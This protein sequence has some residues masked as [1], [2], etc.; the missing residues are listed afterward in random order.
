MATLRSRLCIARTALSF[1]ALALVSCGSSSPSNVATGDS[2]GGDSDE[3][4]GA[5]YSLSIYVKGDTTAHTFTDGYSGQTPKNYFM[6]VTRFDL[7]LSAQDMN[8]VPVFDTGDVFTEMDMLSTTLA[9]TARL[10]DIPPATYTHGR[11]RLASLRAD[12]DATVHLAGGGYSYATTGTV[13][14]ALADV[15][16][17]GT[18]RT[19]GWALFSASVPFVGPVS[20]ETTLPPLPDN[21]GAT[22]VDDGTA[23]WLVFEFLTPLVVD[24]HVTA[25][26]KATIIFDVYESFR[27]EELTTAGYTTGVF[28]VSQDGS[29]E[30]VHNFGANSYSI[31]IE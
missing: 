20:I 25:A 4:T 17:D 22:V 21:Q 5:Q 16:I 29:F 10:I 24:Y 14:A 7:M 30:P 31:Q 11:V 9:G 27:W 26:K 2:T 28:D 18:P 15:T 6:G 3:R 19:K 8:P 1:G 12:V 23:T 13:N